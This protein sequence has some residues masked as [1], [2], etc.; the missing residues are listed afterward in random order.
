MKRYQYI[1][2]A[3]SLI[4]FLCVA[5]RPVI[6]KP[7]FTDN[8][9]RSETL[10][11]WADDIIIPGFEAYKANL[12]I[13]DDKQEL[14]FEDPTVNHLEELRLSWVESYKSWQSVAIFDIGKAE[15]ISLRLF[16][17][18]YPTDTLL[19]ETNIL[20]GNYNLELPSNFVAQGFPALDYLLFAKGE[21]DVEIINRLVQDN[22]RQYLKE[23]ISRLNSMTAS[24]LAHWKT[25][26]RDAFISNDGS[27][28]TS[29]F[30]KM[31]NDFLFYYEKYFRA[32]KIGIP[33]GV[34][35]GNYISNAVEAPY[36]Q[37]YSKTLYE[38]A[39]LSL[40]NFFNGVAFDG[41]NEGKS[42]SA[43][44][45]Y[46]QGLTEGE[47]LSRAINHQ[48]E[49]TQTKSTALTANFKEGIEND[50]IKFL[51]VYDELQK[52]VILL[53]VD[54]LQS[55]NVQIDYVDADGD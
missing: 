49:L 18:I 44:L 4:V 51:E 30:D 23:L 27:S 17:N 45:D 3:V 2:L 9:D 19:I 11:F 42:L 55:L 13:L 5:C 47:D 36:S 38:E 10:S 40:Q 46:I 37:I 41:I 48:W 8:F 20:S 26:Y 52:A 53:K 24:V 14:F 54:M 29:S 16:T 32:G 39:F 31:V 21:T 15:S 1:F 25:D 28:A 50:P 6:D 33:A 35:S 22:Y 12:E 34:F 7:I 43:Y